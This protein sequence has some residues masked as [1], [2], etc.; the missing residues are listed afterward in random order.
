MST[1]N[2][3][4]RKLAALNQSMP[5]SDEAEKGLLSCLLQ[6]PAERVLECQRDL[7][8]AAFYHPQNRTVYD[9]LL[10]MQAKSEPIDPPAVT[11]RLRDMGKLEEVG[12]AAMISELFSFIPIPTHFPFYKTTITDKW[13]MRRLVDASA[14]NMQ[15]A[16]G[17]GSVEALE[18][19]GQV[20]AR[21]EERIFAVLEASAANQ[22]GPESQVLNSVSMTHEWLDSFQRICDNRGKVLGVQ[23]G[24]ADVDRTFHGLAPDGDG[25]L[26]MIGAFPGMGKTVGAVSLIE[27]IAVECKTPTLVFPLEMG[28]TGM[29][30]R[31][32]LGR[33]G[34]NVNVSRNGM[35]KKE[36][37]GAVSRA[38]QEISMAPIFWDHKSSITTAE[39][40]AKVQLHVRRHGVKVVVID[41]FGQL[42]PSSDHGRK[43]ERIGQKE[44]ME[45]LHE[46]RRNLGVLV[47]LFVQLDKKAR[48]KQ[49]RNRPPT[50]GD[51]RG[52]SEMVEYPTHIAFIHRPPEVRPW[53]ALD[54]KEQGRWVDLIHG[55][56]MDCPDRWH[57]GRGLPAH[58]DATQMDYMEHAR[59]IIAKNRW[60]ATTDDICLR[61]RPAL[62]RFTG[63]TTHL[64]SNNDKHRQVVLPGF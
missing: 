45:C 49:D 42:K 3:T 39:L 4:E 9:L 23:T 20:V 55:F 29:C 40:R 27:H 60:G 10:D 32:Y 15:E 51:I 21:A 46:I 2:D 16:F 11:H 61:F 48:E 64:Y 33:S 44:I 43:D 57:D 17:H 1:E 62:Q 36:D 30:H 35:M 12:G 22:G 58:I 54:E 59:F 34:V 28:R 26:L 14:E 8:P 52:A 56:R 53:H 19:A 18:D 31:L 6:D 7:L 47:V 25:D 38:A 24:W 37:T 13:L 5:F 50:P 63:R 41:H